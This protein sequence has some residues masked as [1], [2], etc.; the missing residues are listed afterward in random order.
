MPER[1]RGERRKVERRR[2]ERRKPDPKFKT[3]RQD[4]LN[5]AKNFQ[6]KGPLPNWTTVVEE[7]ELPAQPL[8]L[9]AAKT[10]DLNALN[11]QEAALSLSNLG[12]EVRYKGVTIAWEDM[13]A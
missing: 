10:S 8:F 6:W 1:R 4:V 12:F 3:T 11:A 13:P 7:R 9:K 5:A 2:V